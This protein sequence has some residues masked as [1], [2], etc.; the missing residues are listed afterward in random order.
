MAYAREHR[1]PMTPFH[2]HLLKIAS[3]TLLMQ[4]P[5]YLHCLQLPQMQSQIFNPTSLLKSR[6]CSRRPSTA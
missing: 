2:L 4:L 3:M 1:R 5:V 6:G